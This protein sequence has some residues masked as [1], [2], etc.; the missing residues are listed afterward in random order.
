MI[1]PNHPRLRLALKI[2]LAVTLP[3]WILPLMAA[4]L[5]GLIGGLFWD[6]ASDIVDGLPPS[7]GRG[8]GR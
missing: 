3:L 5:F 2:V 6:A 7:R 1:L 8:G 4:V